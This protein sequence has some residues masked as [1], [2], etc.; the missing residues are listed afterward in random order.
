MQLTDQTLRSF[1]YLT[2]KLPYHRKLNQL[3]KHFNRMFL[4]LGAKSI[5]NAKM[6][7]GTTILADLTTRTE[8]I[9]FYTG[10][11]DPDFIGIIQNLFNPNDCFLDIGAN[12][13]FYSVSM[14]HFIRS[15]NGGGKVISF[16]PF[17]GN[18]SRLI[19]NLEVND[20]LD[21]CHPNK[22]GLSNKSDETFIT[23]REDF[24]HGSSTGNAAI[25]T[26]KTFD[27]GFKL[28]PIKLEVLD[29]F[30]KN[31]TFVNDKIDMVK[32]DIEGHEDF[33]LEGGL[34]TFK[35]HRPTILMEVNKP[36]YVSR[37]VELDTRF[38]P[39]IPK[40]YNIY[41]MIGKYWVRIDSL[42]ACKNLDNVFLVPHEKLSMEAYGL[43]RD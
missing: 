43:F 32:M 30:W 34:E 29:E 31:S 38:L 18:Y 2:R 39:L 17:E 11:Y 5:V 27:E 12:I 8:R 24:K 41:R 25:P 1:S 22:F 20:L 28:S 33:C 26:S 7:D 14:G 19:N 9:S 42:N 13:G 37:Q 21:I 10:K 36:Y 35:K 3:Y 15:K 40:D 4:A 23:L 6:K 16:E